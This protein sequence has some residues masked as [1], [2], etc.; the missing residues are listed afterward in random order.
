MFVSALGASPGN[1]MPLL[2]AKGHTEQRLRDS[3]MAW[4]GM[5]WTIL[6]PNM[7]L[8]KLP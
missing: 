4:H 6:Q 1:P 2:R 8:D 3:G 5:A 7:F